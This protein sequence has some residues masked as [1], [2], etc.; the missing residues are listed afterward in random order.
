M[1]TKANLNSS[2]TLVP[3]SLHKKCFFLN[4]SCN[5]RDCTK[6]FY[7]SF[8]TPSKTQ[9]SP[10]LFK[11]DRKPS[12]LKPSTQITWLM[13]L[14][15]STLSH[16]SIQMMLNYK[17]KHNLKMINISRHSLAENQDVKNNQHRFSQ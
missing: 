2:T 3:V 15:L 6:S 4:K 16:F 13:Y 14:Y 1:E 7:E 9:K 5:I 8:L 11:V 12:L 17:I 10:Q